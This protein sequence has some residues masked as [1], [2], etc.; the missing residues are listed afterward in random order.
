[1]RGVVPL[2]LC[3]ARCTQAFQLQTCPP[4]AGYTEYTEDDKLTIPP[5]ETRGY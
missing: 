2:L 4:S 1:M 3:P 5:R